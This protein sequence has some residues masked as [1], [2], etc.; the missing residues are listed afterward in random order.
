MAGQADVS[1]IVGYGT[2]MGNAEDAAM[3]FAEAVADIGITAEAERLEHL[4]FSVLALGDTSYEFFCNAGKL[5]DERLEAL[6]ATRLLDCV[7]ID[8]HYEQAAAPKHSGPDRIHPF[9]ARLA[10]NRRLNSPASDK[11]VR[12][13]EV[14]LTG[15]A[16]VYRAGDSIA[17]HATNDPALVEEFL[18]ELGVA[19]DHVVAITASRSA[20]C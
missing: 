7:D 14:D 11:E 18:A 15:S 9:E 10:V 8:G 12:H 13:Y 2:D 4:N 19:P 3:S 6:G 20:S 16:I 17:V 5:V 1:L